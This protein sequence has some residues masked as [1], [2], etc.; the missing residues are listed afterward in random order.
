MSVISRPRRRIAAACSGGARAHMLDG[1]AR[2]VIDRHHVHAIDAVTV[3][4]V[5]RG[6]AM[7]LGHRRMAMDFSPDLVAVV[8][9]DE[10][11]RQPP[12]RRHVH[13]L[14][15]GPLIRRAIAEVAQDDFRRIVHAQPIADPGRDGKGFTDDGIAAEET[16]VGV[17]EM[18]GATVAMRT[19][20]RPPEQLG[21]DGARTDTPHHGVH[22]LAVST[23]D[24][25][26]GIG[27]VQ[28]ADDHRLFTG[29]QMEKAADIALRVPLRRDLL[30]LARKRHLEPELARQSGLHVAS[31]TSGEEHRAIAR[32]PGTGDRSS[33]A[34]ALRRTE[35]PAPA[36]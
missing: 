28:G 14:M 21:H 13:R 17:E 10:Q 20:G 30:E 25:V 36:S 31:S 24:I 9:A 22:V 6:P 26:G 15:E 19:S 35:T 29:I 7:E 27:G 11:Y 16:L 23:D 5:G 4:A 1:I 34:A 18:H 8:L 2:G 33:S 3:D 12:Q 32:R